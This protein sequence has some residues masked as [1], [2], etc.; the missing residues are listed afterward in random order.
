MIIGQPGSGKST[1]ARALAR[2]TFLP[3]FHIDHIHWKAGWVE[4]S[5]PEKDALCA[6][7]HARSHWIFEGGRSS[8]WPARL[9]RAD[10]LIWLDLPVGV[11]LWRVVVRTVR[12]YGRSRPDLPDG[13]P[14]Q[15]DPAFFSYIWRTRHTARGRCRDLF[16]NCPPEKDSYRLT[17][18]AEVKDFLTSMTAA[19]KVGNLGIPHR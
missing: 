9:E 7:V 11:R 8:T 18:T 15:F 14:E 13:C 4:R 5:G 12:H 16:D 6:K 2:I 1:F 3:V 17:S 10:M 19:L